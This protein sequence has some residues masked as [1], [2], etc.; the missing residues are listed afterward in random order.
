M[1]DGHDSKNLSSSYLSFVG[2]QS[3]CAYPIIDVPI[4]DGGGRARV[5]LIPRRGE[6]GRGKGA[7]GVYCMCMHINFQKFLENHITSGHLSY[8]DFCEV[9]DFYYVEDAY[10]NHALCE[11]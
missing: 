10:H 4:P 5:S 2:R 8:T 1:I 9:A 7:P 11:R 3:M 6:G